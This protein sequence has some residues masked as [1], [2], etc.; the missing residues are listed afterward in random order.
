M[1]ETSMA[2]PGAVASKA[3]QSRAGPLPKMRRAASHVSGIVSDAS[4]RLRRRINRTRE[5]SGQAPVNRSGT[6]S[7]Q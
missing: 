7:S 2:K 6:E 1:R 3:A 5:A 4:S